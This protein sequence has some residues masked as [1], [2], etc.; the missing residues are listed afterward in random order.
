M[1]DAHQSR[2]NLARGGIVGFVG[3]AAS[4]VLG[5]V[6][7]IVLSRALGTTGAGVVTQA[8]GVFAIVMA[9]AKVGLDST[10]IYL[11]PRLSVD[12][13]QE[14][15]AS[16]NY[17]ASV[18]VGVSLSAVLVLEAVAPM[19]WS[20]EVAGAVRAAA[21]FVPIGALSLVASAAL[22]ALGNMREY[23]LVQNLLLPGLR[24][25]LVAVAAAV[26]GS[27]AV[28]SAAWA[29]PFV[30]VLVCAWALLA[31]HMP[32]AGGSRWPT[33]Q[34]RRRIVS[35]ALPRTLTAG[36][37]Q[38]LQW[39]DVLLV[40]VLAGNAASGIYGGAIRF[41]QAGL[42]VD[43]ALRVVVSPQF[44]KLLHQR[45]ME[46]LA[47]LY[48]TASVWLVLFATPVYV[49]MA[50]FS[51]ALMRILGEGFEAGAGVLVALCAG[52]VVTFMAGNI[53]S[54]LIMSGRSGWAAVNKVVVLGLNVVGNVVFIPRFGMLAAA[55]VW[56]VCMV[57]DAAMASVQVARFI[58]VR[59]DLGEVAL[60]V[61]GVLV[62]VGAP[63]GAV[64][65]VAGRD[66]LVGLAAGCAAGALGFLAL[67][68]AGRSPLRL[69]GLGAFARAR[70][71]G[72]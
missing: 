16:L 46:E 18:A 50:V 12:S 69:V 48:S 27:Y 45:K 31:R 66:S 35:F 8:T 67:C 9:L 3:A 59:P 55:V 11:M 30:F 7:T 63:A 49:L 62:C 43:T 17:M 56:A 65:L 58:G 34:R 4:A 41:I 71:S 51:P 53:H 29:L 36:L 25:L 15:R 54:L 72:E 40:G 52:S 23:V 20:A 42:V 61:V 21:W 68:W 38:A 32:E 44:S 22:R 26:G 13:P 37:E 2:R 57:V 1:S 10:A 70:R 19:I 33:R 60:P 28:V 64:A 47:S 5:F 39:L 6:F 24:P 14:I